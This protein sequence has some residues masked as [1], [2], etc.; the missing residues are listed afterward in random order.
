M[1]WI[2]RPAVEG[3]GTGTGTYQKG[4]IEFLA[5]GSMGSHEKKAGPAH[6]TTLTSDAG[7]HCA[8]RGGAQCGTVTPW[9]PTREVL[10]RGHEHGRIPIQEGV[11]KPHW[12]AAGVDPPS[13][14]S[15]K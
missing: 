2:A 13:D 4:N 15:S 1:G 12:L 7:V 11:R 6:V 9:V 3:M 10:Q 5:F 14:G 8:S